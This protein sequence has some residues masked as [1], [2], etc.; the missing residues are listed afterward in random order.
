MHLQRIKLSLL[1]S[2]RLRFSSLFRILHTTTRWS[3]ATP[4]RRKELSSPMTDTE[5]SSWPIQN[6]RIR[7]RTGFQCSIRYF[8][9]LKI[10][11]LQLKQHSVL[12]HLF[13]ELS[14]SRGSMTPWWLLRTH[15]DDMAQVCTSSYAS[16]HLLASENM[17]HMK[18]FSKITSPVETIF[19][20][21]YLLWHL[22]HGELKI[23][24]DFRVKFRFWNLHIFLQKIN[25]W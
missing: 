9:S 13:S 4:T 17:H 10:D 2:N 12:Q 16:E 20:Y 8:I 3:S 1:H 23:F 19:A 22:T 11:K 14:S 18:Y 21:N 24:K 5:T 7:L 15:L 6:W 25:I